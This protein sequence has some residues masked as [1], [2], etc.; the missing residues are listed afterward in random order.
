MW[1]FSRRPQV[2]MSEWT[3]LPSD[4]AHTVLSLALGR[5]VVTDGA[6][7]TKDSAEIGHI[8]VHD[9]FLD[10]S[11][12]PDGL[13]LLTLGYRAEPPVAGRPEKILVIDSGDMVLCCEDAFI[14]SGIT[15]TDHR[16][17]NAFGRARYAFEKAAR[18]AGK[19][20]NT[21]V[22]YDANRNCIGISASP[23]WGDGAY[24]LEFEST[25]ELQVLRAHL[26][27]SC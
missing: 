22:I 4:D 11:Q 6:Y 10:L 3:F 7:L 20:S 5:W 9:G 26:G 15:L 12:T 14:R 2:Q 1:P 17:S 23:M 25:G 16:T 13:E 8:T 18:L 21:V 19:S 27:E 24:R